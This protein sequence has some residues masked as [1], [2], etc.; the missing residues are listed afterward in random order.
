MFPHA[1]DRSSLPSTWVWRFG[2][3]VVLASV[4]LVA[5]TVGSYQYLLANGDYAQLS[6][7]ERL[8]EA[9]LVAVAFFGLN[10]GPF[11]AP[12]SE[13]F[14][15][16]TLGRFSGVLFVSY[17]AILGL[18][19]VFATRLRPAELSLRHRLGYLLGSD[20]GGV[21]HVVVCGLGESGLDLAQELRAA[22]ER[23][24]A[25]EIDGSAP[26]VDRAKGDGITVF[27]GDATDSRVLFGRAKARLASEIY[28]D[29]GSDVTNSTVVQTLA[30]TMGERDDGRQLTTDDP[31]R[32]YV[33]LTERT[34]RHH[35]HKR[36]EATDGFVL[37]SY[38]EA[39]AT[40][41]EILRE[42][43][44][45]RLPLSGDADRVHVVL[46]GWTDITRAVLVQLCHTMHYAGTV[47]REVTV[48]CQSAERR[49]AEFYS[50]YPGVDA[51]D[52]D[53]PILREFVAD[54]F[55][56][57]EFTSLPTSYERLLSESATLPSKFRTGDVLSVVIGSKHALRTESLLTTLLPR[58][59]HYEQRY[60]M[61]TTVRYY[62]G[63]ELS[64]NDLG[65]SFDAT[66]S[67]R[68]SVAPFT[69]LGSGRTPATVRGDRRDHLAKRIALFYYLRYDYRPND[70]ESR[71]DE[72]LADRIGDVDG[73][74]DSA[75]AVWRTLDDDEIAAFAERCWFRLDE[76][77]RDANRHAAEHVSTKIRVSRLLSATEA[78][79]KRRRT[80][81]SPPSGT[82]G[83]VAV[84]ARIEHRRWC[85]EK[86]LNGWEPLP[87]D[88][89]DR[90]TDSDHRARLRDQRYHRDIWPLTLL[91]EE[92]PEEFTKDVDQVRFVL[93]ELTDTE[94]TP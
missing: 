78:D 16:A 63:G 27:S 13:S 25:I 58:L 7:G 40:A 33:Q 12:A 85:A 89:W 37:H 51:D 30:R 48:V 90:W 64:T 20:E 15:L 43:P 79:P 50:A 82:D 4:T 17:A 10:T 67:D 75:L 74:V 31:V 5:G 38:D 34:Y 19:L 88:N 83:D 42:H 69:V 61:D 91:S 26:S 57:I 47:A 80:A 62:D 54:L 93:D 52:W 73:T 70:P 8:V 66:V 29:C 1:I 18:S 22:N 81:S 39:T 94:Y 46:V 92:Y 21:G 49:A 24:V 23:V 77:D 3:P 76:P 32:C 56:D 84:L 28:V 72:E 6:H 36:V 68:L 53:D 2:I 9:V 60:E 14:P 87:R 44:V 11:P 71:L 35:L 59:E 65:P 45:G 86:I 41:R 55:P